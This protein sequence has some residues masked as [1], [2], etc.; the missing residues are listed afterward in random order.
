MIDNLF[1]AVLTFSVLAAG[2]IAIGS[3]MVA[4]QQIAARPAAVAT[5]P[6]V[7]I[8]GKRIAA[9]DAVLL[10]TVVI[11][12]CRQ[13]HTEVAIDDTATESRLQ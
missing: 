12:G 4:P 10:P 9:N 13:A 6:P 1:S 8:V 3:E 5:L 7:T 2:T 11:T